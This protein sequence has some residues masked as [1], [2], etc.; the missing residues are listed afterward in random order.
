[1]IGEVDLEPERQRVQC[2]VGGGDTED[3]AEGVGGEGEEGR[4]EERGVIRVF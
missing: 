3:K 1:M 2:C 4:R